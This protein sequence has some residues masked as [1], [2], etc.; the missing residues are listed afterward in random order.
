MTGSTNWIKFR[1]KKFLKRFTECFVPLK[2]LEEKTRLNNIE[3]PIFVTLL[4]NMSNK[5]SATDRHVDYWDMRYNLKHKTTVAAY[6][7]YCGFEEL[8]Q[9][10]E[11]FLRQSEYPTFFCRT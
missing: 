10:F 11:P 6:D 2:P 8:K 7:W 3:F 4:A 1:I 9:Y 5:K